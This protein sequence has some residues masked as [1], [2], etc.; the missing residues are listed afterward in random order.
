M[1]DRKKIV[2]SAL[3]LTLG[4]GLASGAIAQ[5]ATPQTGSVVAQT[6][7]TED[8]SGGANKDTTE[9]QAI[10]N[11][12]L[13]VADAAKAAETETGGKTVDVSIGDENGQI[14][15]QVEVALSDGTKKDVHVDAQTGKVIKV[16][17]D[18]QDREGGDEGGEQ[19][20]NGE[21]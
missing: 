6:E 17:A 3:L 8:N 16:S 21:G 18:D 5:T 19:G 14:A 15:Y 4:A 7:T 20:E 1:L 12:K 9:L 2:A 13:T 10:Q 11:A